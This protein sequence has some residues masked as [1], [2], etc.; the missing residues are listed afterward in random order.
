MRQGR[1]FLDSADL[2]L[3]TGAANSGVVSGITTNPTI[4][5]QHTND[6]PGHLKAL[7]QVF[8][9]GP[10]FYQLTT[11]T[12][13]TAEAELATVDKATG[14]DRDRVVIKLPAQPWLY[15]L[16]ARLIS[17]GRQVAFTAVYDPGQ[18][19]CAVEA[20]ACWIIP[21]VDRASRLESDK[22]PILPR[23]APFVPAEVVL[24]AAS[25]KSTDQALTAFREGADA[26]TT[27]W[28]LIEGL[29]SHA[30]TDSAVDEF[31][32]LDWQK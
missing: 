3:A 5:H 8:K 23:L 19:V 4:M 6:A 18:V 7:L 2:D 20:G 26:V 11:N 9:D 1:L 15:G 25:I 31:M 10:V 29:M 28:P 21:Y 16:A 22:G 30:L 12:L 17:E 24:L 32:A 14:A 13:E 27:T